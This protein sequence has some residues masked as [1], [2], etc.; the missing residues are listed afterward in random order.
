MLTSS[1]KLSWLSTKYAHSLV[2]SSFEIIRRF[3]FSS[4]EENFSNFIMH[5]DRYYV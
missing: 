4:F 2:L 3:D 1:S 5:L